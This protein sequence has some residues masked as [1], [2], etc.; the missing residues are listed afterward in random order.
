MEMEITKADLFICEKCEE[1]TEFRGY[2]HHT[3]R[4][5]CPN[6]CCEEVVEIVNNN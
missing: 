3:T 4:K 2:Y 6:C 1:E 5:L